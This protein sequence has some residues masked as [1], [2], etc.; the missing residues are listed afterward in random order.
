MAD[1]RRLILFVRYPEPGRVKTRLAAILGAER[2][3]T[4]YRAMAEDCLKVALSLAA[5]LTLACD[6]PG[7]EGKVKAWLGVEAE[8]TAQSEGDLGER[9]AASLA[10]AF[11]TGARRVLLM[12]SDVPDAPPEHLRQGFELLEA[13]GSVLAPT[14]DGGFWCVGFHAESFRPDVFFEIPWS[15]P[16]TLNAALQRLNATAGPLSLLPVWYDIDTVNDLKALTH[17]H[18]GKCCA[19]SRVCLLQPDSS[20]D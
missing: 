2:A 17:R 3:A 7:A 5:P 14:A 1:D 13:G 6:P 9:M 10:A 4:L 19:T 18:G 12:G 16:E 15:S 11:A 20:H 8:Y